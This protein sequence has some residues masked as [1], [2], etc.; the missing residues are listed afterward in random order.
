[1][2]SGI[3]KRFGN[4]ALTAEEDPVVLSNSDSSAVINGASL[5]PRYL[6]N[7]KRNVGSVLTEKRDTSNLFNENCLLTLLLD[8]CNRSGIRITDECSRQ[9]HIGDG[10]ASLGFEFVTADI[11]DIVPV[12]KHMHQVRFLT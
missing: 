5:G 7:L 4:C 12:V 6:W 8:I 11:V 3:R 1:M 9:L 2:R 10:D